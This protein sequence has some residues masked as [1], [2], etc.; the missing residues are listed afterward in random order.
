MNVRL[1]SHIVKGFNLVYI[2]APANGLAYGQ[3]TPMQYTGR[4]M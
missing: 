4:K 3:L 1:V 2:V